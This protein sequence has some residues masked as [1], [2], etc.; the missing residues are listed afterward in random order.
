[1]ETSLTNKELVRVVTLLEFCNHRT[2]A[3]D[4]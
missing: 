3:G 4:S 1:M 2:G